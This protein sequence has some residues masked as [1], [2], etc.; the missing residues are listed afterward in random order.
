MNSKVYPISRFGAVFDAHVHGCFDLH[1]GSLTPRLLAKLSV[2]QKFNFL[3]A[4]QHDTIRGME[5]FKE[6]GK[7]FGLPVIPAME[8]STN[9]NHLLAYGIQEWDYAKDTWDPEITIERLREQDCAIYCSHPAVYQFKGKWEHLVY[10]LD[11]DG[12]EWT[13][14]NLNFL[15]RKIHSLFK[16]YPKGRI[17]G[18]DAHDPTNFGYSWTQVDVQSE[19]PDDLVAALKK[20][21]CKPCGTY[22]PI[23]LIAYWAIYSTWIHKIKKVHYINRTMIPAQD[24]I[25][26]LRP[27]VDYDGREWKI[28]FLKKQ[29]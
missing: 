28:D 3:N 27:I 7:E 17:A 15:N 8:V 10:K 24:Y 9:Y 26:G 1:D 12:I 19:D 6:A 14:G 29:K 13:N 25:R 18:T 21:K 11:V 16:N 23:F 20:G 22:V 2:K 4:M 5:L